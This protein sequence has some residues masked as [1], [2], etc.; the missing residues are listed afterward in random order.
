[1]KKLAIILLAVAIVALP[2]C[3]NQKNQP[4]P[5]KEEPQLSAQDKYLPEELKA[6]LESLLESGKKL[7]NLPFARVR[8]D[9]SYT[10]TDAEKKVKP[11]YLLNPSVADNA[12]T[13]TQQYRAFAMLSSDKLVAELYEMPVDK[14]EAAISKLMAAIADPGLETLRKD[15]DAKKSIEEATDDFYET[16]VMSGRISY[17]WQG[18][19][20]ALVEQLY[21]GTRNIDKFMTIFTDETAA[22]VTYNFVLVHENLTRLLKYYPEMKSLN[23]V[24]EPLY[25]INAINKS[26]LRDQL[27][28]LKGEIEAIRA[29]LLQ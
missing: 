7:K 23:E 19:S 1:M 29:I 16:E 2:S 20:A 12:V 9:G 15:I 21:F 17:F 5:A 14:Y 18:L 22:D 6:N 13:L 24:L 10:L 3:K 28:E 8:E 26:Q 25:V 4:A 11:D 27:F